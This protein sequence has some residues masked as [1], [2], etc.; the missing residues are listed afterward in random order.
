MQL[1]PLHFDFVIPRVPLDET[2]AINTDRA[3]EIR[4]LLLKMNVILDVIQLQRHK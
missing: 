1:G 4:F 3:N 2:V